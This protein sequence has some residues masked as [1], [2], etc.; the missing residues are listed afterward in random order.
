LGRKSKGGRKLGKLNS[1]KM[2]SSNK[3][4]K[5][6]VWVREGGGME[7]CP[8]SEEMAELVPKKL[9]K[10]FYN[11]QLYHVICIMADGIFFSNK[12]CAIDVSFITHRSTAA[13]IASHE[14]FWF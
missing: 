11:I 4:N 14:P 9:N 3:I 5:K 8:E 10:R 6:T 13:F 12:F 7:I 1:M 2:V